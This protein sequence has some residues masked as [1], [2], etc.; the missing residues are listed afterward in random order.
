MILCD[1]K[2]NPAFCAAGLT[3]STEY[4]IHHQARWN[5]G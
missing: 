1:V 2:R 3:F 4:G 5:E